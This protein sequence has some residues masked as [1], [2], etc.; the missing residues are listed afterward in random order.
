M[1]WQTLSN[2]M[3]ATA[4]RT[5]S[6][7]SIVIQ[8]ARGA[9]VVALEEAVYDS[10]SISVDPNSG[11]AVT[12]K[13]PMLGVALSALPGGEARNGDT[14]TINGV[15]FRVKDHQP[16]SEGHCRILLNKV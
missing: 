1:N 15:A 7:K 2:R 6:D 3:L 8:Y 13:N 10:N 16:D 9:E 5:F 12:S 14:V 11:V 4:L